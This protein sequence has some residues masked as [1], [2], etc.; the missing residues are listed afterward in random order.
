[1]KEANVNVAACPEAAAVELMKA[2][3]DLEERGGAHA[4]ERVS[5]PRAYCLSLYR[6]CLTE[7]RRS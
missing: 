4:D 2:V 7:T 1:M 6:E 3:M 5:D